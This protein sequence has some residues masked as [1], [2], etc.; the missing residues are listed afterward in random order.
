MASQQQEKGSLNSSFLV[1]N[2]GSNTV[3]L[4]NSF[5]L[6]NPNPNSN[7]N[8][9]SSCASD[10]EEPGT[11]QN[12]SKKTK[13]SSI[14]DVDDPE[15]VLGK[16]MKSAPKQKTDTATI[17][18]PTKTIEE[19]QKQEQPP[20]LGP[21]SPTPPQYLISLLGF[22]WWKVGFR[23]ASRDFVYQSPT[24][25]PCHSLPKA[26][27][28]F[29]EGNSKYKEKPWPVKSSTSGTSSMSGKR[30]PVQEK[31]MLSGI[32]EEHIFKNIESGNETVKRNS[33]STSN[34]QTKS[35]TQTN[36]RP[37]SRP[38]R[39]QLA[40]TIPSEK[41]KTRLKTKSKAEIKAGSKPKVDKKTNEKPGISSSNTG[42][43][44]QEAQKRDEKGKTICETGGLQIRDYHKTG[45]PWCILTA[46]SKAE[47]KSKNK[48]NSRSLTKLTIF[49]KLIEAG[50]LTEN[51]PVMYVSEDNGS[52]TGTSILSGKV[53]RDGIF[54]DCC[55][56]TVTVQEFESHAGSN[57]KRPWKNVFLASGKTL[58]NCLHEAWDSARCSEKLET[59]SGKEKCLGMYEEGDES[60][61][62]CGICADG[63]RL[64]FC[65]GCPSTFHQECLNLEVST[66]Y[67]RTGLVINYMII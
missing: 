12:P 9:N 4:A 26:F 40:R 65:D 60:D 14:Q 57:A 17:D 62:T 51:Q 38:V 47:N 24:G 6:S 34:D 55:Q 67:Q 19:Q 63:G 35:F 64:I 46:R 30:P 15:W 23:L 49:S 10:E 39:R 16:K 33:K 7:A 31:S 43:E 29:L 3:S 13:K 20:V 54:C 22:F 5:M 59:A 52:G 42:D 50:T 28:T 11:P 2:L 61:D 1:L 48:N 18:A 25:M 8:L 56:E 66:Q 37:P 21:S 41:P 53:A 45:V 58:V 36:R 27:E 44:N 32:S